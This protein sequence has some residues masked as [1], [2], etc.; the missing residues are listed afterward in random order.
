MTVCVEASKPK[1][2]GGWKP[3]DL[4][5]FTAFEALCMSCMRG[6]RLCTAHAALAAL[7]EVLLGDDL[8]DAVFYG[9][10]SI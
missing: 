4:R 8:D 9:R 7:L 6:A 1:W 5:N 3:V 2:A 10:S